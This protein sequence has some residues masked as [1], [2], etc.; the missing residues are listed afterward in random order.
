[1]RQ[2]ANHKVAELS[3]NFMVAT[4]QLFTTTIVNS[5]MPA[6]N[7]PLMDEQQLVNA[8]LKGGMGAFRELIRRYEKLVAGIVFRMISVQQDREDL[9]QDIFL[10]VYEKLSSFRF[11]S[12][13]STWIGAIAFNRCINF[14]KAKKYLLQD[15][16]DGDEETNT[17]MIDQLKGDELLIKKQWRAALEKSIEGLPVLQRTVLQL[18]HYEELSLDEIASIMHL[19]VNT[20]K[21]HLFRARRNLKEQLIHLKN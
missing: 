17:V 4:L 1:M 20:V 8:V 16:K 15:D 2:E 11:G 9:C 18:F 10:T 7:E 14:L 6:H 21:S 12:K 13:L 5:G 19:P 3:S